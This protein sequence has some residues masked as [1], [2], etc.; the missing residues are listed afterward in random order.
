ML[1]V[2]FMFPVIFFF[3]LHQT[4]IIFMAVCLLAGLPKYYWL[5]LP[6]YIVMIHK[7]AISAR[8]WA[9]C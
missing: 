9:L 8:E 2:T 7:Q 4:G 5:Y 3:N 1:S 6:T